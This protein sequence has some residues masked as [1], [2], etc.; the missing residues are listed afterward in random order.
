MLSSGRK[1]PLVCRDDSKVY[2]KPGFLSA[3]VSDSDTI[4]PVSILLTGPTISPPTNL[5]E[6][7]SFS[8]PQVFRISVNVKVE[9]LARNPFCVVII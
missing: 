1:Y 9:R 5:K 8:P 6:F 4:H 3:A 7:P 2:C